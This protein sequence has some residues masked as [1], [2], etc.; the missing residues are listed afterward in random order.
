MTQN[1]SLG[2]STCPND[3]FIF[4]AMTH[5][6]V[7]C[8]SLQF[9]PI[10]KDVETLNQAARSQTLDVTKLSFAAIG[11]LQE[12]YG[13]LRSGAA[14]GRGCGP[15]VVAGSG[16]D[17]SQLA[18][19]KIAVPGLWTTANLLLGLYLPNHPKVMP[20]T[21]DQIM[22]AVAKGD[23][24]YGVIIHEGRFTFESYG[25]VD[26][27][28]LGQ[29]WED[30]TGLPIPLGGIAIRRELGPLVAKNVETTI[31]KSIRYAFD[32]PEASRSYI[33]THAQEMTDDVIDQH[34]TL[35][36]NDDS[37]EIGEEGMTAI[38]VLFDKGREAGMIPDCKKELFAY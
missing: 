32:H 3:T 16:S 33:K 15:L 6:L 8:G 22:P 12:T 19:S 30:E 36:V 7:D 17:L 20:M 18:A 5:G 9:E 1:L 27:L 31:R 14:L 37:M 35:Y 10:L 4:H 24:E 23:F 34:I 29:W 13:L 21:F 2:F 25:L 38:K 28:D 26:L 11:Q